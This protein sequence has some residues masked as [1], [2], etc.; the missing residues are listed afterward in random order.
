VAPVFDLRLTNDGVGEHEDLSA[1]R[2]IG[3]ALRVSDHA[4]IE[5]DFSISG[6]ACA[7]AESSHATAVRQVQER[8]GLATQIRLGR[9]H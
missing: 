7:E 8:I 9:E 4:R 5:H 3:Q 6:R 2:R 1:I